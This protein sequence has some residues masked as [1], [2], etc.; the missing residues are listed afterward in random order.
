[1]RTSRGWFAA[2]GAIVVVLALGTSVAFG[3]HGVPSGPAGSM[4][5]QAA[6]TAPTAVKRTILQKSDFSVPGR[7]VVQ[8]LI[9]IPPGSRSGRHTHPGEEAGYILEGLLVLS[10]D[11]KAP[12]TL[13]AGE[14]FFIEA[15]RVHDAKSE[16]PGPLKILGTYMVAKDK[17][18]ATPAP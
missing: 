11:G 17:P 12:A 8:A 16:G 5:A 4:S 9:E 6:G 15:E 2:A 10:V 14:S 3:V 18:L 1:M 13:K 7:E